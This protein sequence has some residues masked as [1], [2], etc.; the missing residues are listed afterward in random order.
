MTSLKD[1]EDAIEGVDVKLSYYIGILE[2]SD[3]KLEKLI[4]GKNKN[5]DPENVDNQNKIDILHYVLY[6]VNGIVL[7]LSI[8]ALVRI[9]KKKNSVNLVDEI[10][11]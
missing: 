11:P 7:I 1:I 9:Y 2:K 6:G 4:L 3:K 8:I 5:A 10:S